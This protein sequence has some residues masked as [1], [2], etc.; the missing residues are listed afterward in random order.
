M[1]NTLHV[2]AIWLHILGVALFV[3][4]QFFLAFAWAPAARGIKD[5]AVRVSLTRQLTRKFGFLGGAG[6]VLIVAAGSYLISNWRS[7]YA[8]PDDIGF[9]DIRYGV[10]FIAKMSAFI[11]ML[12]VVGVHSFV[13]G[14]RL[15]ERME[16]QLA[17]KASDED[18]RKA[19]VASMAVSIVGLA[20]ALA[21]MVLGVMMNT[22]NF[23]F[24]AT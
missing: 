19:R 5:Q 21:I 3:G 11:V 8:Q 6:L 7:Y 23:S 4:P 10:L 22:T 2:I 24:Q 12:A 14:P 16:A 18:V 17:G 1:E 15:V 20:L 9:T 13:I